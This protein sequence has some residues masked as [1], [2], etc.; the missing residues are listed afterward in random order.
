[1][2]HPSSNYQLP[3]SQVTSELCHHQ[4]TNDHM[5][6]FHSFGPCL[7]AGGFLIALGEDKEQKQVGQLLV[8]LAVCLAEFH[9]T[10]PAPE[11]LTLKNCSDFL[12]QLQRIGE[13]SKAFKGSLGWQQCFM[14]AS[15]RFVTGLEREAMGWVKEMVDTKG[16]DVAGSHVF[17][18]PG[19]GKSKYLQPLSPTLVQAAFLS[20][21]VEEPPPQT[22]E[23]G[24]LCRQLKNYVSI[25]SVDLDC[26]KFLAPDLQKKADDH[27]KAIADLILGVVTEKEALLKNPAKTFKSYRQP[28]PSVFSYFTFEIQGPA[29]YCPFLP[30]QFW[31]LQR[32]EISRAAMWLG[33][34]R[35]S[36]RRRSNWTH[37]S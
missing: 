7:L 3:V 37:R 33:C 20:K 19:L 28:V 24:E 30:G 9:A 16:L 8:E 22:K 36:L 10:C 15:D 25:H 5:A 34:S 14:E 29:L 12:V 6:W 2:L 17:A 31:K 27:Q 32:L 18:C 26:L 23:T 11:T 13:K 4:L 21:V 1:M 35:R